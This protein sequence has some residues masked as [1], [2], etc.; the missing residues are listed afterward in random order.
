LLL[1]SIDLKF[2]P[3]SDNNNFYIWKCIKKK[4]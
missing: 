2:P 3:K 1:L 4:D